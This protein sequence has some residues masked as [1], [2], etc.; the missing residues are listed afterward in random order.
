MPPLKT[1]KVGRK[2]G[3]K[4]VKAVKPELKKACFAKMFETRYAQTPNIF[5]LYLALFFNVQVLLCR[6]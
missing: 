3:T 2:K 5:T 1:D 4:K 6:Y